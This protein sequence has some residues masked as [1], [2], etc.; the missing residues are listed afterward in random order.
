MSSKMWMLL[1]EWIWVWEGLA[2]SLAGMTSLKGLAK[3]LWKA[4]WCNAK[5]SMEI[6]FIIQIII[7]ITVLMERRRHK[8]EF[9]TSWYRIPSCTISIVNLYL[10]GAQVHV[11]RCCTCFMFGNYR[12]VRE[13]VWWLIQVTVLTEQVALRSVETITFP[14]KINNRFT[15]GTLSLAVKKP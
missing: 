9:V 7:N 2:S 4:F 14:P 5:R 13:Q 8:G 10:S 11:F 3:V 6:C 1:R 15:N 12:W